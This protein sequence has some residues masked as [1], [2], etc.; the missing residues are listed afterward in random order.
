MLLLRRQVAYAHL[1]VPWPILA[2]LAFAVV[3]LALQLFL[4]AGGCLELLAQLGLD[5]AATDL[6][7]LGRSLALLQLLDASTKQVVDELEL[8][9]TCLEPVVVADER[10]C[11]L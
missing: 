4:A 8:G 10:L 3:Q 7:A 11:R 1:L 5:L 6:G 9:H 2:Q